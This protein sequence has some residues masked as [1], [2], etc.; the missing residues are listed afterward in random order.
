MKRII[1]IGCPGAGKSTFS[2]KLRD[3]TGLGL[4]Y[5]DTIWHRPDRTHISRDEFDERLGEIL[6]QESWIIDGN[7]SRTM[8][9]RIKASDTVILFDLPTKTCLEGINSRIGKV[10]EDMPW[11]DTVP[12]PWLL[13]SVEEF[14]EKDLPCIYELLDKYRKGRTIV[15]F[16]SRTEADDFIDHLKCK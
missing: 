14:K 1:V 12:D 5:L 10:R 7:Y 11:C 3:S 9:Q 13:R 6:A 2:R 16:E 4:F 15:I 8:E